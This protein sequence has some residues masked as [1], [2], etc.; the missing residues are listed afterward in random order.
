MS[1]WTSRQ[2]RNA[3]QDSVHLFGDRVLQMT[4]DCC[5]PPYPGSHRV[6]QRFSSPL[7]TF[8]RNVGYQ[9]SVSLIAGQEEGGDF[10]ALLVDSVSSRASDGL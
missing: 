6:Y 4:S 1:A 7:T 10:P 5:Q 8:S 2:R 9:P 3:E